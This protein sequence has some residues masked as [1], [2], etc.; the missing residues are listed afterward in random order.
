M[1]LYFIFLDKRLTD[2]N[3]RGY[4]LYHHPLSLFCFPTIEIFCNIQR[5]NFQSCTIVP[6]C[7]T[8]AQ[9]TSLLKTNHPN[10][11]QGQEVAVHNHYQQ[12]VFFLLIILQTPSSC[13]LW[14]AELLVTDM[15]A[16]K[17]RQIVI[18]SMMINTP[19]NWHLYGFKKLKKIMQQQLQIGC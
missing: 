2:D 15:S 6:I 19:L 10:L 11:Q 3:K 18:G 13:V 14:F 8:C 17:C 12:H 7:V 5:L 9:N 1:F 4:R 16:E